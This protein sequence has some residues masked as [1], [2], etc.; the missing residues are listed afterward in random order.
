MSKKG[1]AKH[2]IF[3]PL[4][5]LEATRE[6]GKIS[7]YLDLALKMKDPERLVFIFSIA[8]SKL[9]KMPNS[10][11]KKAM[12]RLFSEHIG[13]TDTR[14]YPL[15]MYYK[16]MQG[17]EGERY[18]RH[19]LIQLCSRF[20]NE[21]CGVQFLEKIMQSPRDSE[22]NFRIEEAEFESCTSEG[23]YSH[24][25]KKESIQKIKKVNKR[26]EEIFTAIMFNSCYNYKIEITPKSLELIK[27]RRR[28][29]EKEMESLNAL[30][31]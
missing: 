7:T 11:L 19:V 27:K 17:A 10:N 20:S 24:Q 21:Y 30:P 2:L 6:M 12:V 28:V 31:K 14:L 23:I 8:V 13:F 4:E 22:G 3:S 1:K 29:I 25:L 5:V 26:D 16:M 9:E 15:A 18:V